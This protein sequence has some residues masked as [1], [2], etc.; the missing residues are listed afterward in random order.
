MRNSFVCF[1]NL[2]VSNAFQLKLP[3]ES[4]FLIIRGPQDVKINKFERR[5]SELE[6]LMG[7]IY[8]ALCMT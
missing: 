4:Y 7:E 5:M 3:L 6:K 2:A 8:G 1:V